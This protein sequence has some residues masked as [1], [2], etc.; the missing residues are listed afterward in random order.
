MKTKLTILTL[1][2]ALCAQAADSQHQQAK[3]EIKPRVEWSAY[4]LNNYWHERPQ[5]DGE[6]VTFVF[7]QVARGN[8]V[9]MFTQSSTAESDLRG[10]SVWMVFGMTVTGGIP[11]FNYGWEGTSVNDSSVPASF[12]FFVSDQATSY[13][14]GTSTSHPEHYWFY[15]DAVKM[16]DVLDFIQPLS[17][18]ASFTDYVNWTDGEGHTAADPLYQASF[19]NCIKHARQKGVAFGGGRFFDVGV[20]TSSVFGQPSVTF[21]LLTFQTFT[22]ESKR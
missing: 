14:L 6:A 5:Q 16:V 18:E 10:Q 1:L 9:S 15:D 13:N 21:R 7:P 17:Y 2:G 19:L 22:P 12:R 11:V 8:Y 3:H 20:G 4:G